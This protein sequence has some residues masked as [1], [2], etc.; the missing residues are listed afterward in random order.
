MYFDNLNFFIIISLIFYLYLQTF[1]GLVGS[2]TFSWSLHDS[3]LYGHLYFVELSEVQ[4]LSCV[5]SLK[6]QISI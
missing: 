6:I 3:L 2:H 4:S 1:V 5:L